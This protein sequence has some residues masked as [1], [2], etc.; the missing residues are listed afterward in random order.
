MYFLIRRI[1]GL[2][3]TLLCVVLCA[4]ALFQCM[5]SDPVERLTS[6][7]QSPH[8]WL[9]KC[10]ADKDYQTQSELIRR[11][12]PIFY[13][14][15]HTVAYPDTL[16]RIV[17]KDE[18]DMLSAL[19][20]QY[21]NWTQISAYRQALRS[22]QYALF[23]L[24]Q[25]SVSTNQNIMKS[26]VAQLLIQSNAQAIEYQCSQLTRITHK[27]S[28][29]NNQTR[30]CS[31]A[32]TQQWQTVK[33]NTTVSLHF[34]PRL[35]WYGTQN[36]FHQYI[37]A[38][39]CG[40]LGFSYTA[41]R[42]LVSEK[43][44]KAMPWTLCLNLVSIVLIYLIAIPLG[45]WSAKHN[46][47]WQD[48]IIFFFTIGINSVPLFWL[49]TLS[50][51]LVGTS[52]YGL[53]W[54]VGTNITDTFSASAQWWQKIVQG[55]AHLLLPLIC[56]VVHGLAYIV[57][58]A[59]NSTSQVLQEDYIRTARAKGLSE[60]NILWQ[61]AFRNSLFP[62]IATFIGTFPS[63]FTGSLLIENVFNIP[64]MGKLLGDAV[65]QQ[66]TPVILGILILG[67]FWTLL[68]STMGEIIY[69]WADPRV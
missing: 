35:C 67:S 64:G 63:L 12:L 8:N 26:A 11:N 29:L 56:V 1:S 49:G 6:A 44:G 69:K 5:T 30:L 50:I 3:F 4:F 14:G 34:V 61:H 43:I 27:D 59:R 16:F 66:D 53:G 41:T 39:F 46:G 55:A 28:S 48:R 10:T 60:R 18:R 45:V 25:D 17:R 52:R 24:P 38:V 68:G 19:I 21:G 9:E 36:Q 65:W 57:R 13:V 7:N 51:L 37:Y 62:I 31:A 22:L 2:M 54:F 42:E 15:L 32:V 33:I 20:S 58:Q 23:Q 47:K 40:N